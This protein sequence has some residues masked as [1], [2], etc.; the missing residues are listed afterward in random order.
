MWMVYDDEEG[1]YGVYDNYQEAEK[2]YEDCVEG[3]LNYAQHSDN[4]FGEHDRTILAKI[5]KQSFVVD[6]GE[7]IT[8]ED[9][10]GV[11]FEVGG[12]YYEFKEE[13]Y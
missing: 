2:A 10:N 11:E 1:L 5:T 7:P 8:E 9:E 3:V 4:N 12:T 6:T 13:I